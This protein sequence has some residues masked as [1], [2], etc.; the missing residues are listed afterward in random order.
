MAVPATVLKKYSDTLDLRVTDSA[1]AVAVATKALP[2]PFRLGDLTAT[3]IQVV[4]AG[5]LPPTL[6]EQYGFSWDAAKERRLRRV[7]AAT[8]AT[9]ILPTPVRHLGARVGVARKRPLRV[10]W[11]QRQGA[12]ITARRLE[13]A[14]FGS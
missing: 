13:Q 3:P 2:L 6:R 10:P 8:R 5:L 12:D 11:L 14:G 9:G 4:T 1:R 7:F